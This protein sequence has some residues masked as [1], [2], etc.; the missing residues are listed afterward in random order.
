MAT[1]PDKASQRRQPQ[2]EAHDSSPDPLITQADTHTL[3]QFDLLDDTATQEI[4]TALG[5]GPKRGRELVNLCGAS[6]ATI[7][8]RVDSLETFGLITTE[9]TSDTD[10][11]RCKEFR[12]LRDQLV[13]TI[14]DG[15]ISLVVE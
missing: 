13:V 10:G 6:R 15:T 4:L 14:N 8:R 7:Y 12:L 5:D 11:H 3:P 9:V 1:T 2:K